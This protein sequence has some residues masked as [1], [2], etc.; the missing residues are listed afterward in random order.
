MVRQRVRCW[1]Y[2]QEVMG[3]TANHGTACV[4]T[5]GKLFTPMRYTV[6]NNKQWRFQDMRVDRQLGKQTDRH[7]STLSVIL[8]TLTGDEV[9]T[10]RPNFTKF[11]V[12][13]P[14]AIDG[15]VLL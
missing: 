9:K 2:D 10:A 12:M 7:T 6:T 11:S 8:L 3:S 5:T 1:T 15:S 14:V 4:T 13:L